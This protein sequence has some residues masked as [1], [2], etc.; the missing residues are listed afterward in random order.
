[1]FNKETKLALKII[2]EDKKLF[3]ELKN[4]FKYAEDKK[5]IPGILKGFLNMH[6]DLYHKI[7]V[8]LITQADDALDF[9]ELARRIK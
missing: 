3:G 6:Q 8:A 1:M 5:T 7:R 4:L 9:K 2:K